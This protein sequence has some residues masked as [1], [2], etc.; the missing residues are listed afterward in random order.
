M[1]L[2][3]FGLEVVVTL[4]AI[5][6]THKY[7]LHKRFS[8]STYRNVVFLILI[9]FLIFTARK[10]S[11]GQGNVYTVVRLFTGGVS[12]ASQH[13]SQV[14]CSI[15]RGGGGV[16]GGFGS[17]AYIRSHDQGVCIQEGLD[18]GDWGSA[19][20]GMQSASREGR[21]VCIGP[22]LGKRA[23]RILLECFLVNKKITARKLW[24]RNLRED[25]EVFWSKTSAHC[26]SVCPP[27]RNTTL[28]AIICSML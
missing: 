17:P 14:T 25:V 8:A 19:S 15:G 12:L 4:S 9:Q 21:G 10:R 22:E 11:L 26:N 13:A 7:Y 1:T 16:R 27:P 6:Y 23:V 28:E 20:R 2:V 24:G 3:T 5:A 18:L